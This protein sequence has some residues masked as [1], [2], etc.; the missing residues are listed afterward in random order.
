MLNVAT[1][2]DT[3]AAMLND[4][5]DTSHDASD[6]HDDFGMSY[7]DLR[8]KLFM[9]AENR[10][11]RVFDDGLFHSVSFDIVL[12]NEWPTTID[13]RSGYVDVRRNTTA[14]R[15]TLNADAVARLNA[16]GCETYAMMP[17]R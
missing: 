8:L 13:T 6:I 12:N 17:A 11:Y 7:G 5:Y 10:E 9:G 16:L 14:G 1:M 15:S 4:I 2:A 3:M